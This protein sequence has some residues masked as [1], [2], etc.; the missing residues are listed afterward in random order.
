MRAEKLK[1]IGL[2]G[3]E[4]LPFLK[5]EEREN[6]EAHQFKKWKGKNKSHAKKGL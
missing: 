6:Y 4:I 1:L 5:R 2:D 3:F